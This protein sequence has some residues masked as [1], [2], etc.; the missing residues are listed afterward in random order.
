[1]TTPLLLQHEDCNLLN[2]ATNN[3]TNSNKRC[4]DEQKIRIP[5]IEQQPGQKKIRK[6]S[7]GEACSPTFTEVCKV[8]SKWTKRASI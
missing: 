1:M 5:A 3:I 7:F 2:I 8:K 6:V 4:R